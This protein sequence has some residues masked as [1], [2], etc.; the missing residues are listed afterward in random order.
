LGKGQI[1]LIQKVGFGG[2]L[3][4][5]CSFTPKALVSWI[6]TH[7]DLESKAITFSNGYSFKLSPLAVHIVLGLPYGG[8]KINCKPTNE[9]APIIKKD[10][11]CSGDSP[12]IHELI[13]LLSGHISGDSFVRTFFLF[14]LCTFLCPT[15]HGHA[16]PKYFSPLAEV[17]EIHTYN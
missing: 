5:N 10:T 8:K 14:A 6:V 12:T 4:L 17:D 9:A 16:S 11:N 1:T 3:N 15:T 7:F 2:I 13:S